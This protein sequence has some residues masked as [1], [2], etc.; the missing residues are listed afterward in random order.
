MLQC[1]FQTS[2]FA[3]F[4][5]KIQGFNVSL[6]LTLNFLQEVSHPWWIAVPLIGVDPEM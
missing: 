2:A 6:S 3:H 4:S 5:A 1:N